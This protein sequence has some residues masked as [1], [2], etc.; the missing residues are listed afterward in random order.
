MTDI[1][2]GNMSQKKKKR[3]SNLSFRYFYIKEFVESTNNLGF[4]PN[5]SCTKVVKF[6]GLGRPADVVECMCGQK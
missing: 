6:S 4:C 5:P 2:R 3:F 1:G